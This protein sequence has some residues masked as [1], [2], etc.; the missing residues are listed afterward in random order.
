MY[1]YTVTKVSQIMKKR[2]T[3]LQKYIFLFF[4]AWVDNINNILY[5]LWAICILIS[6]FFIRIIKFIC[7]WNLLWN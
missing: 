5:Q 2:N 6:G 1:N 4:F 3:I 7:D